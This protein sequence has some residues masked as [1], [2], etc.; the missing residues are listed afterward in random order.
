[1][2]QGVGGVGWGRE[3]DGGQIIPARKGGRKRPTV[4]RTQ[5]MMKSQR[6]ILSTTI[7]TYFQSSFTY[8]RASVCGLLVERPHLAQPLPTNQNWRLGQTWVCSGLWPGSKHPQ[9]GHPP[10]SSLEGRRD[11]RGSGASLAECPRLGERR[12]VCVPQ[13]RVSLP[14]A[15]LYYHY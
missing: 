11:S 9:P 6:N 7:A 8:R 14:K 3:G 15:M 12:Q 10:G 2:K 4:P 13:N 5:T 1:M